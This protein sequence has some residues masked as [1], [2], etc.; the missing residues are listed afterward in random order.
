MK[1]IIF[2]VFIFIAA[3]LIGFGIYRT[4]LFTAPKSENS[5]KIVLPQVTSDNK[6]NDD[7][8]SSVNDTVSQTS[9]IKLSHDETL[10]SAIGMDFDGDG[11]DDQICA[12]KTVS[13]PYIVVVLG[14]YNQ[15]TAVYDRAATIATKITQVRSFSISSMDVIGNHHNALVC[16]GVTDKGLSV[17]KVLFG[18]R[19]KKGDLIITTGG[20]FE[21][22]G[23]VFIQQLDRDESY[24]LSQANGVSFPVWVYS[25]EEHEGSDQLD[26]LQ[27]MY[28]WSDS[29]HR[30]V[31]VQ[32]TRV[33][34]SRLAEKEL[35]RIQDGTVATFS[36][37][38]NGLWYKTE[39]TTNDIRYIYFDYQN[40]EI[41]FLYG[42][43]EEVYSLLNSNVRRS[44]IYLSTVNTSI[45]NLQRRLD[46]SLVSVDEIRLKLQDDVRMLISENTLWDGSY[47]KMT[48]RSIAQMSEKKTN[49][50]DLFADLVKG[51]AW[52][53]SDNLCVVFQQDSYQLSGDG[54]SGGGLYSSETISGSR[55]IE[56]R[57]STDKQLLNGFYYPYYMT[58][59]PASA[60][61]KTNQQQDADTIVLQ[62]VIANPS[63]YYQSE[64]RP[65]IFRRGKLFDSASQGK[66]KK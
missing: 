17:L 49:T 51:P 22:D 28:N 57:P 34:G 44:G 11:Y 8:I 37:F 7:N 43:S 60:N 23:S 35:A 31:Q 65:L 45:E 19:N 21:A 50:G 1:R 62:P 24:E 41:I 64:S 29:E 48:S 12:I 61:E 15:S 55:L 6:K 66:A 26:Q 46:I 56:F 38:L 20:D 36:A 53:T 40:S 32:Q 30:Y 10:L 58:A 63:G 4:F 25:T 18:S 52:Y 39:N 5:A 3:V 2:A 47:K 33:A 16:Q 59:Q 42:D 9:F 14:L 54:V 13:N 27:T